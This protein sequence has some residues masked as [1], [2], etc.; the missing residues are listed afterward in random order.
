MH[1]SKMKKNKM[2]DVRKNPSP[3]YDEKNP[4]SKN[5][6]LKDRP[7]TKIGRKDS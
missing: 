5:D 3:G 7:G 6:A 4:K 1:K 2:K